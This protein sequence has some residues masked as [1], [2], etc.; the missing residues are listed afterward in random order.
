MIEALSPE[1]PE[2]LEIDVSLS[3]PLWAGA[4]AEA[5]KL[6]RDAAVA[7]YQ[8]AGPGP[9]PGPGP[10]SVPAEASIVLADDAFVQGLNR[11]Y[12]DQD[13]PTNVLSFPANGPADAPTETPPGA[14]RMLGDIVV[15]FETA[16]QEAADQRKSIGDHLCHLVVHGMLH[17]LGHDH[18]S[19]SQAEAM[20]KLEIDI[21]TG[22]EI[23]NPYLNGPRQVPDNERSR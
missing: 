2:I 12:R 22:L 7:A 15:A 10:H 4:L 5:E 6:A 3:C 21:L 11:E 9:S 1:P 17:L 13:S 19:A 23:A 16:S 14:P 20:E 18:Q 8:A